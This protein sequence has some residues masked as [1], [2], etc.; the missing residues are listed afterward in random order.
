M[1][2]G[3]KDRSEPQVVKVA[4]SGLSYEKYECDR[5]V[6][7]WYAGERWFN[8]PFPGIFAKLDSQQRAYF[9]GL[10]SSAIDPALP[11]GT[12]RNGGRVKS[13][14]YS[15]GGLD[16]V[17]GGSM[18]ALIN[19]DDGTVGIVDY[20]SSTASATLGEAYM[21]QLAAYRWALENPAEGEPKKVSVAG[22]L[23]FSPTAM[24]DTDQGR[25]NLLST[26]WIPVDIEPDWILHKFARLAP[27]IH[28]PRAGAIKEGCGVCQIRSEMKWRWRV[29]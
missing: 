24:V 13:A 27:L 15:F 11:P 29:C 4:P 17:I 19:F 22:L 1:R 18:D 6:G 16:F 7:A 10:P 20:K 25:A 5:C 12:I 21:P 3:K 28:D 26:T 8:N 9:D 2:W 23:V 14:P